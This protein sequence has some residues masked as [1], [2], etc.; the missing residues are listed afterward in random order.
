MRPNYSMSGPTATNRHARA[1]LITFI[2]SRHVTARVTSDRDALAVKFIQPKIWSTVPAFP[3]VKGFTD[4]FD[5][6]LAEF[7][8]FG[9]CSRFD[10]WHTC[11]ARR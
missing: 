1:Y 9:G 3:S 7:D 10:D 11:P 8:E 4:K 2:A 5:L 6:S